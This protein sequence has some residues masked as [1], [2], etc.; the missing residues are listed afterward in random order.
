MRHSMPSAQL[1]GYGNRR[2]HIRLLSDDVAHGALKRGQM[3]AALVHVML[4]TG[5]DEGGQFRVHKRRLCRLRVIS[6]HS[7]LP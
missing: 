6:G 2:K 3:V 4:D 7:D 5:T 1:V